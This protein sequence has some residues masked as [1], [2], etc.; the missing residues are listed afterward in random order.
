MVGRGLCFKLN[1]FVVGYVDGDFKGAAGVPTGAGPFSTV[2]FTDFYEDA[3]CP[4]GVG[5][6]IYENQPAFAYAM[7]P[8]AGI[9]RLECLVA[10]QPAR[11]NRIMLADSTDAFG[12]PHIVIDYQTH[13]RDGARLEF[14][15]DRMTE[16]LRSCGA[17]WIRREPSDYQLGSCH[18]HGTCRAGDDP[19]S[20]VVTP[21]G[22]VHGLENVYVVDGSTMP[23]PGGVNPTLTIQANALRMA[24]A[25]KVA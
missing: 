11:G 1:E 7:T 25:M 4:T 20:S 24:R 14:M 2:S 22:R 6:L 18:L 15:V 10:D 12:L 8:T 9:V 16:I 3:R 21:D 17:R 19:A 5:G 23:F 13:P